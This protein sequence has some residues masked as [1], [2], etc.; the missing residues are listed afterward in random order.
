MRE[1]ET[2]VI[3][4]KI[5]EMFID[6]NYELGIDV[7]ASLVKSKE[8]EESP[9]G[10]EVL[11]NLLENLKIAKEKQI[12]ICQDTGMAVV[13]VEIG[14]AVSLKGQWVEDAVNEGVKEA[15]EEGYLR[16]SVVSDPLER[17]NTKDNTPAVIHYQI[18][19]GNQIKIEA[20]AKGFGS[21]NMGKMKMLKPS[22]GK[23]GVIKF[24]VDTVSNAGANP[25]PPIIVGVGIGGTMEKSAILAKKALLR[26]LG[27]KSSD[28]QTAE[29]E[30]E[31]YKKI[32][33]LGIG[34][35]GFGGRTTALAVHIEK[36][37]TH[38]AG[39]PITVNINCH[40]ARHRECIL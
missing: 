10:N 25:C 37:P 40:V 33:D 3:K 20:V 8:T 7:Q 14:Q 32:N 26:E 27:Q 38:I 17:K 22:D 30:E 28:T 23:E 1:I 12:P 2:S 19:P 24:V 15:Y 13:F 6:M 11:D 18:V 9:L 39:L 4:R 21:E 5:K 34:P 29:L 31:I 35:Q 36:F 16:K